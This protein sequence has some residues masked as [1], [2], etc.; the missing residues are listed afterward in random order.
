MM[1][2]FLMTIIYVNA[3]KRTYCEMVLNIMELPYRF[4]EIVLFLYGCFIIIYERNLW[5]YHL[6]V[7]YY[8]EWFLVA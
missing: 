6:L 2:G 5:Y 4:M 7:K 1:L 3:A 8:L